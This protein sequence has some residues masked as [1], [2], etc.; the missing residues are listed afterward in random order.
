MGRGGAIAQIIISVAPVVMALETVAL[1]PFVSQAPTAWAI[2]AVVLGASGFVSFIYAKLS[3]LRVEHL[4]SWGPGEMSPRHRKFYWAGYVLMG[5][6]F[7]VL[8]VALAAGGM[9]R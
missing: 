2:S 5:A 7:L 6:S 3:V 4:L 8:V 1:M 9:S